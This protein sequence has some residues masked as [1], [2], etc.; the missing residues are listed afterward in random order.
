MV[1]AF[2]TEESFKG[3]MH[4]YPDL[5]AIYIYR[6]GFDQINSSMKHSS[7]KGK[8]FTEYCR[9]YN[10]FY[11]KY[12]YLEKSENAYC[13]KHEDLI[14]DPKFHLSEIY[15]FLDIDYYPGSLK[16]LQ[17]NLIHPLDNPSKIK[18]EK[19]NE[20]IKNRTP[21]WSEWTDEQKETFKK[22]CSKVM[23]KRGYD[24]PF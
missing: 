5:K 13:L 4:L 22:T 18:T 17:N 23:L 3:L 16:F 15:E 24:I 1:K 11:E 20:I 7:F 6:N 2:P 10:H 19:A 8:E 12:H 21:V 9:L 14:E